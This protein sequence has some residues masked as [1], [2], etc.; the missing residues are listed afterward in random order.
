MT[1]TRAA[2]KE[3]MYMKEDVSAQG[4][5]NQERYIYVMGHVGEGRS[6]SL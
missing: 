6:S 1:Q 3:R 5:D 2:V 4:R